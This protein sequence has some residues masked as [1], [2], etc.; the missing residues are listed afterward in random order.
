MD[1]FK[2]PEGY[3]EIKKVN[4]QKDKKLAVLVNI[5]AL[6]IMIALFII[7]TL[8]VP[9]SFD[10]ISDNYLL[11]LLKGLGIFVVLFLYI[12]AHELVHGIFIKIFSGKKAKYGFTGLYAY[13]GSEAY[14]NKFHYIVIALAPVVFF[15]FIFLLL[16]IFLLKEW[17]WVIYIIQMFNLSGAAGDIYITGLIIKFPKDILIND[18][19][20]E[21][22]IYS[23]EMTN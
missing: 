14:F 13:A 12:I 17:F 4:L 5:G 1:V 2:L 3:S 22:V 20:V 7:G 21:M 19:G 16:N 11:F 18:I 6:V 23:K 8:V 9:I 15:G 10:T